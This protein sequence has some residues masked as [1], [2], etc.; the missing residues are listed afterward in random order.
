MFCDARVNIFKYINTS[1]FVVTCA[2]LLLFSWLCMND[3]CVELVNLPH[4]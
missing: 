2:I 4:H 3:F 1:V